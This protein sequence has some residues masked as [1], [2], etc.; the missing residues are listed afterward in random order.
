MN[1]IFIV[2]LLISNVQAAW[3]TTEITNGDK[4]EIISVKY[5]NKQ[6]DA[7][8]AK[9]T[10]R[11]LYINEDQLPSKE[12][13]VETFFQGDLLPSKY[14][15]FLNTSKV[16]VNIP[17][18]EVRTLIN[19]GDPNNRIN[20]TILGDGYQE[21]ER[22]KFFEDAQRISNDLFQEVT[23]SSFLPLF[24]VYA[25]FT[26][27]K[28]SG[29]TDI[30][31]K[32]TI[33]EL[34]RNP[35]GS[36][37]GIMPGNRYMLERA[38]S[39]APATDYPIVIA[40]DNFYGGLGGRYAITT[41]SLTSGSMVLR[42][43]LGHNFGNVGE[44]Y[45]G[46]Y[47][48]SG[49]NFSTNPKESWGHWKSRNEF[50]LY[51]SKFL[52]GDYIWQNLNNNPFVK[53]FSFNENKKF[54]YKL[55]ISSVGWSTRE[56]VSVYLDGVE[57]KLDGVFTKDRSFFETDPILLE[58]GSHQLKIIEKINDGDNV[59]A[60]ANGYAY[61]EDYDFT[62]NIIDG[63]NVFASGRRKRGY[64]PTENM[65][66]MRNM[67]SKY[68]CKVDQENIWLRFLSKLDL[69]DSIVVNQETKRV[70]V[71]TLT[72]DGLTLK[73]FKKNG[74]SY[75]E[76]EEFRNKKELELNRND[77]GSFKVDVEFN[78]LEIRKKSTYL[79]SSKSFDI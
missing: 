10:S 50:A 42:H 34:Y 23:F 16:K 71:N 22:D 51:D 70:K 26:P 78:T 43:E 32:R 25:V 2:F 41:R 52:S 48:Y 72:L 6:I 45:D 61:P 59:L 29:I 58:K 54:Y 77:T 21:T 17:G 76:I 53:N 1:K 28:D 56:D 8:I 13:L 64:R 47:V 20:L 3:F 68:F 69:I 46:G 33:F 63:F 12:R 38:I 14:L 79:K 39:L 74:R 18:S 5:L 31:K 44:E 35:R 60:F 7:S 24:N 65:C 55:K 57:L 73:W 37:R 49:A 15:D 30:K 19:Q 75:E 67:R 27:S 62:E 4:S 40:N 36:K 66:L 9:I 11:P